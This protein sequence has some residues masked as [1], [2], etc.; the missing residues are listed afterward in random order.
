MVL[1]KV[2]KTHGKPV[3]QQIIDQVVELIDEKSLKEGESL[4]STRSLATTLGL[5]RST[6]YRAYLELTALGYLESCP[7]SYT[8]VRKRTRIVTG[9][10]P[11][12]RGI[13]D[14]AACSNSESNQL[15][16]F[17][18]KFHPERTARMPQD[19]INLSPLD[20][21]HRIFP[22]DDFRRSLNQVLVNQGPKI[23]RYGSYQGDENLREDIARRLQIHGISISPAEVLI[24][25]GAQNA[26]EL[27]L[28]LL[29]KPGE[30]VAIESP[31]YAN[32]IP[33][34]RHHGMN[35]LEVPVTEKGMDLDKLEQYIAQKLPVM[36]YTI[37]NF[38]NPTGITTSQKHRER[39]LTICE[40]NRIPLVEDGFEEEMKYFGKAVLPIKSMDRKKIVVYLGTFSKVLFPGIRLGWIAAEKECIERLTSIKRFVDLSGSSVIQSAVS[41]FIRRGYYDQHLKRMHRIFRKRMTLI[42]AA[43]RSYLPPQVTWTK[44]DGGYT[45]WVSLPWACENEKEFVNTLIKYGVMVS[46]GLYYFFSSRSHR[47]FRISI[48][49]LNED[50]ITEGVKRLG[51]ALHFM[52]QQRM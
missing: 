51:E 41:A 23:L 1:L 25:N 46:P 15:Y 8:R 27:V 48:S 32:V 2:D 44:P 52:R 42:L 19:L 43:L 50:E 31:T 14:W 21:D 28:K 22:V 4:P 39:L 9:K 10:T 36:V 40:K 12:G 35:L 26:I 33:L 37:P 20:L 16:D 18:L 5:D 30:Y 3:F 24:T 13:I 29:G 7:G 45:L 6:V 17:F 34:I 47:Y 38:Q 49:S 11:P